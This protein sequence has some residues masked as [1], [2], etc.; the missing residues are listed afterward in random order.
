MVAK[1]LRSVV[2]PEGLAST[3][4]TAARIA[5]IVTNF[6][7]TVHNFNHHRRVHRVAGAASESTARLITLQMAESV[8]CD[9][10]LRA[11]D[12][13]KGTTA[14]STYRVSAKVVPGDV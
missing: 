6:A 10:M 4:V 12:G 14:R 11:R 8:H 3:L 7:E 1:A 13:Q 9:L 5:R 2:P